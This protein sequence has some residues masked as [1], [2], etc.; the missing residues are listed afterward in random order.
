MNERGYVY[1]QFKHGV[2]AV[3]EAAERASR[4]E[5]RTRLSMATCLPGGTQSH[6]TL[7]T[8]TFQ[9]RLLATTCSPR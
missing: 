5:S 2:G 8:P 1:A 3:T 6:D 7:T 9:K 4:A